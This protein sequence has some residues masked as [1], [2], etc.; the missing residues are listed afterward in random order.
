M[1]TGAIATNRCFYFH[2]NMWPLSEWTYI[3]EALPTTLKN[4]KRDMSRENGASSPFI[5]TEGDSK[6][7]DFLQYFN[8]LTILRLMKGGEW[9]RKWEISSSVQFSHFNPFSSNILKIPF[10]RPLS[11]W[12]FREFYLNRNIFGSEYTLNVWTPNNTLARTGMLG[13][14]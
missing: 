3:L 14:S 7:L 5:V 1:G 2:I 13:S 6:C 12:Y 9:F 4:R 10:P 11:C 8:I